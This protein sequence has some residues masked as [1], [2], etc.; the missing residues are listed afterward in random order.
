MLGLSL[1]ILVSPFAT[2]G[3]W[4][5]PS[6]LA[7][8]LLIA[9][10]A[11]SI[12]LVGAARHSGRLVDPK[13]PLKP[14]PVFVGIRTGLLVGLVVLPAL[15]LFVLPGLYLSAR[16]APWPWL[17]ALEGK[18]GLDAIR[19][20]WQRTAPLPGEAIRLVLLTTAL[21]V[22]GLLG[23]VL[24]AVPALALSILAG[25]RFWAGTRPA[26]VGVPAASA[27][28]GRRAKSGRRR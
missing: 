22:A 12:L 11:S 3:A 17:V 6:A 18:E 16:L 23:A 9:A 7:T 1:G 5:H 25:A 15:G 2:V 26:V 4:E 13:A 24:L 27:E 19:T 20:A 21:L 10:C 14:L 28:T 8:R